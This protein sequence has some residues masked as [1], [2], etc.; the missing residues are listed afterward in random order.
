MHIESL[1]PE[2]VLLVGD[3]HGSIAQ[4]RRAL[5]Y[6]EAQ[7]VSTVV[8]LGDFGIWPGEQG[9]RFIED[10]VSELIQRKI[11][12]LFVDGNHEDFNQ[13]YDLPLD[14]EDGT[15]PVG[16]FLAHLPRGLRWTWRGV[17]FAALGGAHSVDRKW[18]LPEVSWWPEEWVSDSELEQL[19]EGDKVDVLFMHDSPSG[20]PNAVCDDP[21]NPGNKIFPQEDLYEAALHRR[22]LA[23]AVDA[24]EPAWIF[25]GHYHM[26]MSGTYTPAGASRPCNVLG[27]DEGGTVDVEH[28]VHV[29]KLDELVPTDKPLNSEES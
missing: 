24:V 5:D 29:I 4:V 8:Q 11:W 19:R 9:R 28:F 20:A 3:V 13:L 14:L 2:R 16:P 7:G 21:L 12:L 1:D 27:L 10:V 23:Y 18:R 25:H 17:R 15:R 26:Y 22:R 6:A